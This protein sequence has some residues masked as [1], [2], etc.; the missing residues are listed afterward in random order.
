MF[1]VAG[2]AVPFL[3]MGLHFEHGNGVYSTES[4]YLRVAETWPDAWDWI[5]RHQMLVFGVGLGGIGGPQRVYAPSNFNPADNMFTLLYA[6]F[7]VFAFAYLGWLCRL[8]FRPV[9]GDAGSAATATAILAFCFGYG[10]VLSVIEDQS[11]ALF[12]GAAIGTLYRATR[13]ADAIP[14]RAG[15]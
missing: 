11:A 8:V 4:L 15:G 6:Y 2:C 13:P 3:A 1:L 7:G 12:L 9:S 5:V 10:I 14:S